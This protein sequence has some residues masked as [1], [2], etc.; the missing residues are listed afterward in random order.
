MLF[1][2]PSLTKHQLRV[3]AS[4]PLV[5]SVALQTFGGK[6]AAHESQTFNMRPHLYR[7]GNVW[8]FPNHWLESG[9]TLETIWLG[10]ADTYSDIPIRNGYWIYRHGEGGTLKVSPCH[11]LRP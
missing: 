4:L 2:M 6:N 10:S 7:T 9:S 1:D 5:E 3:T 8:I 11:W